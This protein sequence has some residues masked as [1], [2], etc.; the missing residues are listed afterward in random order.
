MTGAFLLPSIGPGIDAPV[1]P[2]MA[3]YGAGGGCGPGR[4]FSSNGSM[5]L[6][7]RPSTGQITERKWKDGRTITFGA[8]LSAYRRRHRLVFGTNLQGWNRTRAEIELEGIVEKSCPGDVGATRQ[9][10]NR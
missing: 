2:R 3:H 4:I 6:R 1:E 10:D 5:A 7:G 8:R 9:E